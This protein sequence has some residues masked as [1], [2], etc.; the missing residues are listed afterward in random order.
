MRAS[1]IAEQDPSLLSQNKNRFMAKVALVASLGALALAGNTAA[2][3]EDPTHIQ[4][5]V[6]LERVESQVELPK[7]ESKCTTIRLD[8][9]Y[10]N[11]SGKTC[12]SEGAKATKVDKGYPR[13]GWIYS[14]V[15]IDGVTK[16]GYIRPKILPT[17]KP[18]KDAISA[19]RK[20]LKPIRDGSYLK[21]IN[22]GEINGVDACESGTFFSPVSENCS[23]DGIVYKQAATGPK[24][25]WNV[26]GVKAPRFSRPLT[27][28]KNTSLS[29]RTGF[30]I[31]RQKND[32]ISVRSDDG[33]ALA[34]PN[35]VEKEHRFGGTCKGPSKDERGNVVCGKADPV[36]KDAKHWKKL[37]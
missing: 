24:S 29:F 26:F 2:K 3:T 35:C 20:Y 12:A 13:Y 10:I 34:P 30:E 37:L 1:H 11:M 16:C 28:D 31:P 8:G 4:P 33:W 27:R 9:L 21:D 17:R 23:S 14:V 19:C 18:A 36:R 25:P 7:T 5:N 15:Y 22:C 32:P 6:Q